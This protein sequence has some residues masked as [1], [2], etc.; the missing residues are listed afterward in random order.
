MTMP[1]YQRYHKKL[2]LIKYEFY[3]NVYILNFQL[4]ALYK[5]DLRITKARTNIR[6]E[7][8]LNPEKQQYLPHF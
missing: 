4:W 2:C 1:D 7:Q 8:F 3:I 5:S 6:A